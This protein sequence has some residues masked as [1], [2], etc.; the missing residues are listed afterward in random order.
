MHGISAIVLAIGPPVLPTPDSGENFDGGGLGSIECIEGIA[1]V[2][3]LYSEIPS[4]TPTN[5]P[6]DNSPE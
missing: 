5:L 2:I 4:E 6:V 1:S 3:S